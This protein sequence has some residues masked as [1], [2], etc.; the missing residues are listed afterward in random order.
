MLP[1]MFQSIIHIHVCVRERERE[2][3]RE[4]ERERERR[5]L[6]EGCMLYC[7]QRG[8]EG[9]PSCVLFNT[10]AHTGNTIGEVGERDSITYKLTD[11]SGRD[12]QSGL[13]CMVSPP[14][15]LLALLPPSLRIPLPQPP[16]ANISAYG[17]TMYFI[18]DKTKHRKGFDCFCVH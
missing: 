3:W 4:R 5:K 9:G 17:C 14:P 1:P 8:A 18:Y 6:G 12:L 16:T 10:T 2:M 15:Y 11:P 13:V 7:I